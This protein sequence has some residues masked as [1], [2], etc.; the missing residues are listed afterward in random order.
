M[1]DSNR[2]RVRCFYHSSRIKYAIG[3]NSDAYS[4]AEISVVT[5]KNV[6]SLTDEWQ[7]E[8]EKWL[9][10]LQDNGNAQK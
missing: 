2:L 10:D 4:D 6:M 1:I 9:N 3:R 5:G 8:H 7:I